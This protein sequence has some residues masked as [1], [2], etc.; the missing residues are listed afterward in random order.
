MAM[1][2][3][4]SR[5]MLH[6]CVITSFLMPGSCNSRV[7]NANPYPSSAQTNTLTS[8]YC[9]QPRSIAYLFHSST[10]KIA[11]KIDFSE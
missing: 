4:D 6:A 2:Y 9:N 1:R 5:A 10:E 8:R 7:V 11:T 3:I